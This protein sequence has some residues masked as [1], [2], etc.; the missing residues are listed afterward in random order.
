MIK[1]VG[2]VETVI[3]FNRDGFAP[4]PS[5]ESVSTDESESEPFYKNPLT[6][7][8]AGGAALTLLGGALL[9]KKK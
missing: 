8:I 9:F 3:R 7:A 1:P 4:P 2:E 6:Y 5:D